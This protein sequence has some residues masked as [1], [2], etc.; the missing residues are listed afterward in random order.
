M[1]LRVRFRCR[2]G[3]N[4]PLDASA[5]PG[6]RKY[7]S[8][9]NVQGSRRQLSMAKRKKSMASQFHSVPMSPVWLRG[10]FGNCQVKVTF[11]WECIC[12]MNELLIILVCLH[13]FATLQPYMELNRVN[14]CW[15]CLKQTEIFS[16][17]ARNRPHHSG[18]SSPQWLEQPGATEEPWQSETL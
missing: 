16:A 8:T 14:K 4:P 12:F 9:A 6:K 3:Q 13:M 15:R 2:F 17:K 18:S 11:K 10:D 7:Q 1:D 5:C